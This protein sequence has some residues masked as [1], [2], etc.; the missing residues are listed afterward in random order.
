MRL[1]QPL[2]CACVQA[3][4]CMCSLVP[5]DP[6]VQTRVYRP[7]RTDSCVQTRTYRLVRTSFSYRLGAV[8]MALSIRNIIPGSLYS[9]VERA[10]IHKRS[11]QTRWLHFDGY[12]RKL[13]YRAIEERGDPLTIDLLLF[14]KVYARSMAISVKKRQVTAG[15]C[16][17]VPFP[18]V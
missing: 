6:Y 17:N 18:R 12:S 3:C 10:R 5:T 4:A 1:A 11:R 15:G 13:A 9:C 8:F 16:S 7:V 14:F 2:P